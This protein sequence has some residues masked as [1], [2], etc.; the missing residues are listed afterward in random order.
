MV[1]HVNR[2]LT[3][4][5]AKISVAR[6]LKGACFVDTCASTGGRTRAILKI[7]CPELK[8]LLVLYEDSVFVAVQQCAWCEGDTAEVHG[9]IHCTHRV[10]GALAWV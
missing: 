7:S 6:V 5:Y 2:V 1:N 9:D 4:P 8:N 10:L 3:L